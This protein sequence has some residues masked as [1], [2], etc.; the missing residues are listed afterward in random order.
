MFPAGEFERSEMKK[1]WK[2][3]K[4]LSLSWKNQ[5]SCEMKTEYVNNKV[6][7]PYLGHFRPFSQLWTIWALLAKLDQAGPKLA[8][9]IQGLRS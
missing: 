3:C 6:T 9:M 8:Q 7:E 2:S 4:N 5:N 1:F